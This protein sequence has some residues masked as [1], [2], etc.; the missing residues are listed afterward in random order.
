MSLALKLL[1][2][3]HKHKVFWT[4]PCGRVNC[5]QPTLSPTA[6][7]HFYTT[8]SWDPSPLSSFPPALPPCIFM[9]IFIYAYYMVL[10][11][12][13]LW[14]LPGFAWCFPL[15]GWLLSFPQSKIHHIT[16]LAPALHSC[17]HSPFL[18]YV[19]LHCRKHQMIHLDCQKKTFKAL[20]SVWF[21]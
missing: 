19:L 16:L 21:H 4:G 18:D 11:S 2:E 10:N 14:P 7:S 9:Y 13:Q 3:Y 6:V 12:S 20:E 8:Y 1:G 15:R 5:Q 17:H